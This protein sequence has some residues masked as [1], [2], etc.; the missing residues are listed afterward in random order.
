[1]EQAAINVPAFTPVNAKPGFPGV[2]RNLFSDGKE[3]LVLI[4]FKIS[5]GFIDEIAGQ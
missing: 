2:A 5:V 1:M 3:S 4:D